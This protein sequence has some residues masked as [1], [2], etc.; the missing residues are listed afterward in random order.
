[1]VRELLA[2]GHAFAVPNAIASNPLF[3]VGPAWV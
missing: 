3:A 2:E 1:L